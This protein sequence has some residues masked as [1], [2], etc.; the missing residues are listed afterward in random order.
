MNNLLKCTMV[1]FATTGLAFGALAQSETITKSKDEK[2][3][4]RKK[5][6]KKEK[7]TIVVDGDNVTVN[8]KPLSDL[9]DKDINAATPAKA[10]A[11]WP[12]N[13]CKGY[14]H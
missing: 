1:A 8:G 7:L 4:I 9:K 2:I 3:I 14:K 6:D 11:W 10:Y 12:A 5:G 13:I